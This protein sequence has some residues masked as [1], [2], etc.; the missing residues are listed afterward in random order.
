MRTRIAFGLALVL[1]GTS[2][3]SWGVVLGFYH[4]LDYAA[5]G[6]FIMVF[7]SVFGTLTFLLGKKLIAN[8][9]E[10]DLGPQICLM[11]LLGILIGAATTCC[12][13]FLPQYNAIYGLGKYAL[14]L[15]ISFWI[16]MLTRRFEV[17][18]SVAVKNGNEQS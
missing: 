7:L 13:I 4:L 5:L 15:I 14:G 11:A 10:Y 2:T 1:A 18:N 16:F 17:E 8:Y 3:I 6:L 12:D 9:P